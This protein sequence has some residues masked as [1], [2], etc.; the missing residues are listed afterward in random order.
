MTELS[1]LGFWGKN[2][3]DIGEFWRQNGSRRLQLGPVS[4]VG[5]DDPC[6]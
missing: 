2:G 4:R 6:F 3:S 5:W 1:E